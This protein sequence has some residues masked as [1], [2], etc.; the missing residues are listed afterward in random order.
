LHPL[1]V[2]GEENIGVSEVKHDPGLM[3]F[4]AMA[5]IGGMDSCERGSRGYRPQSASHWDAKRQA[6]AEKKQQRQ[7]KKRNRR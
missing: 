3:L 5:A 1:L 4:A 6:K 2:V 7:N